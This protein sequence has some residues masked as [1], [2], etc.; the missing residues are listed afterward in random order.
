M[1]IS[2]EGVKRNGEGVKPNKNIN[3]RR[4]GTDQVSSPFTKINGV[5]YASFVSR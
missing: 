4:M 1:G 2:R 3:Q 5:F